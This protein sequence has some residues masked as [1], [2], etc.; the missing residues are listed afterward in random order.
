MNVAINGPRPQQRRRR[1]RVLVRPVTQRVAL[2]LQRRTR[3]RRMRRPRPGGTTNMLTTAAAHDWAMCV[4]DP[5]GHSGAPHGVPDTFAGHS[6]VIESKSIDQV[7]A[8]GHHSY[9]WLVPAPGAQALFAGNT[10]ALDQLTAFSW[11]RSSGT[12]FTQTQFGANIARWRAMSLAFKLTP[13]GPTQSR[14]GQITVGRVP[15][16]ISN[17]WTHAN[18]ATPPVT[19]PYFT[20]GNQNVGDA[21][22]IADPATRV[23]T[24]SQTL[25]GAAVRKGGST[26]EW[27]ELRNNGTPV[28]T[29]IGD[30]SDPVITTGT[31]T[32][33]RWDPDWHGVL[34]HIN[35]VGLT[36]QTYTVET[37]L[38]VE[39]TVLP[40]SILKSTESLA[41]DNQPHALEMVAKVQRA[42]PAAAPA[43]GEN[44]WSSLVGGGLASMARGV[45]G[46][47]PNLVGGMARLVLGPGIGGAIGRVARGVT[48]SL[49]S[50]IGLPAIR[51]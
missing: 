16:D 18:T 23:Y 35:G 21:R 20:V 10:T 42:L 12:T 45:L 41:P 34:L 5:Y 50:T 30:P 48:D 22:L 17:V 43:E 11:A 28:F 39:A 37:V 49:G 26:W 7:D 29:P 27:Q 9:I 6:I 24:G 44:S 13:T 51:Q 25:T 46:L 15:I 38:C 14:G 31:A 32:T 36:G 19:S 40:E 33:Y 1:R 4:L 47:A 8:S 3:R 2:R